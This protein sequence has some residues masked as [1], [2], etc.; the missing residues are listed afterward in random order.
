V[1]SIAR[2]A[3]LVFLA[4]P[5][6]APAATVYTVSARQLNGKISRITDDGRLELIIGGKKS[7][8]ALAKIFRITVQ[9]HDP[10]RPRSAREDVWTVNGTH[11]CGT[12]LR[13][14]R[15]LA[16]LSSAVGR[17]IHLDVA[18][19]L[20]V[21]FTRKEGDDIGEEKFAAEMARPNRET[22]VL[23]VI[24]PKGT[25]PFNVAVEKIA[26]DTTAFSWDD[27]DRSIAT[28]RVAAVVFA[29]TLAPVRTQVAARLIDTSLLRGSIIS[30]DAG[31][32][33]LDLCGTKVVVPMANVVSLELTN[34]NVVY[35]SE[36]QPA[37]VREEPF[38]PTSFPVWKFR[39]DKSVGGNPISLDGRKYTRGIGCHTRTTLTYDIGGRY[40]KFAAV[41]GID[42]EARPQGSV[43]FI[44][45]A[46]GKKI[47]SKTLTGR[48][49]A[50]P[51]LLDIHDV[52]RLTLITDFAALA[53]VGDH[54]DWA[55]ARIMK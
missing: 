33:A 5:P 13:S 51:I 48:D 26:P 8:V 43:E 36:L 29:N 40:K 6:T 12:L 9:E 7:L 1:R 34:P 35:L 2:L 50:V 19:L 17:A 10:V 38:F 47:L 53:S 39:K 22:D 41:I 45:L 49:K 4:A 46:D 37:A 30:L 25:V 52:K 44:A 54:A 15:A 21:K 14:N 42:D 32:L 24:S 20:G 11:V 16:I 55:D 31:R 3:V 27:E 23:F 28:A 18:K